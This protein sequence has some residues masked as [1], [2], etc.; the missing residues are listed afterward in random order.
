MQHGCGDWRFDGLLSTSHNHDWYYCSPRLARCRFTHVGKFLRPMVAL[1]D[2]AG[3]PCQETIHVVRAS[4]ASA[5]YLSRQ[6]FLTS[7][8]QHPS[9]TPA[10]DY[11]LS[12]PTKYLVFPRLSLKPISA[13]EPGTLNGQRLGI[14]LDL[15]QV[16]QALHQRGFVHRQIDPQHIW[17]DATGRLVVTG[18][19]RCV[20]VGTPPAND[21]WSEA[22]D[23][24]RVQLAEPA[25]DIYSLGGWV[26]HWLG[27]TA[28]QTPLVRAMRAENPMD[29]PSATEL[30]AILQ[31]M[32]AAAA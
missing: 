6:A 27:P 28:R 17:A 19:G 10:I 15:L 5:E 1:S 16:L 30:L 21:R 7:V 18:F 11:R 4:T 23:G 8:L 25:D 12:G 14:V 26:V 32:L 3:A 24:T 13:V 22:S 9:V 31:P 29:R 2:V 20:P